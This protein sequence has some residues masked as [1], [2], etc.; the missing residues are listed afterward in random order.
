MSSLWIERLCM[1]CV[2]WACLHESHVFPVKHRPSQPMSLTWRKCKSTDTLDL[3]ISSNLG[4]CVSCTTLLSTITPVI[5]FPRYL[6]KGK[7]WMYQS[8]WQQSCDKSSMYGPLGWPVQ[9]QSPWSRDK[10]QNVKCRCRHQKKKRNNSE[11]RQKS[12]KGSQRSCSI[13]KG[14]KDW[15]K[16]VIEKWEF[17]LTAAY[18][19][20]GPS[21][22]TNPTLVDLGR[23]QRAN[24]ITTNR[25]ISARLGV[26]FLKLV[27]LNE[28]S[29]WNI[30][31]QMKACKC[32]SMQVQS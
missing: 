27:L 13:L 5:P 9:S 8:T 21:A 14:Q 3:V 32:S 2:V 19:I 15:C 30:Y 29:W 6:E 4:D 23:Y 16:Q 12:R 11:C 28:V 1:F 25:L 22:S 26:Y 7:S 18:C 20:R 24:A 10:N 17:K 31:A